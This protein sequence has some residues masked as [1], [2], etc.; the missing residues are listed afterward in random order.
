MARNSKSGFA[1]PLRWGVAAAGVALIAA[2]CSSAPAPEGSA[3]AAAVV[4]QAVSGSV[5]QWQAAVCRDD[6]DAD[7]GTHHT[8]NG[9][10]C[11]PQ[12]G[13]GV[14]NFDHFESGASMDSVLSWTPSPFVAKTVVDGK[15]MA[16]WTPSGEAADLE[17]L[18]GFGFQVASYQSA[19]LS[20]PAG[21]LPAAGTAGDAVSLPPNQYGYV[22]VQ[23][24]AGD[25]QC[26]VETTFVG[27]ET[28][29]TNWQPHA[30]G[31]GPYHGVRI[32][33]DGTGSWVD[34]NL[35]AAAPTTL[36]GATYRAQGWTIGVT[37]AG[38]R[39]TNDQTGHGAV[40]AIGGVQPF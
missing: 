15:P 16:I 23:S 22:V 24:A 5:D 4:D 14:V 38:M 40:V 32:N 1:G 11:V 39:F 17:P 26:I 27:C 28:E 3:N 7:S 34:G 9:S 33:P 30:D 2:G 8:V 18:K 6:T 29:G 36:T 19:A 13:D 10:T 25:T 31:S 35:G 12:D 37:P 21:D 20:K